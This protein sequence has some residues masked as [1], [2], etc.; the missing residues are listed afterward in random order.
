[1]FLIHCVKGPKCWGEDKEEGI[2]EST[3]VLPCTAAFD[4]VVI[5]NEA[6]YKAAFDSACAL[7]TIDFIINSLLGKTT[8]FGC[9]AKFIREVKRNDSEKKYEYKVTVKECGT[10]KR[11]GIEF[12]WVLVPALPSGWTVDFSVKNK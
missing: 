8:K 5:R 11:L 9:D 6:E 10:C 1:M 2:I 12:N 3:I 4:E 7:P